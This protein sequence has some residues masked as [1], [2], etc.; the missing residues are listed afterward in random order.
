M[1]CYPQIKLADPHSVT[2]HWFNKLFDMFISPLMQLRPFQR[3]YSAAIKDPAA[4]DAWTKMLHL[5][6]T[7]LEISPNDLARIPKTG[8]LIVVANHPHGIMDGLFVGSLMHKVRDDFKIIMNEATTMPGLEDHLLFVSILG[9]AK[10]NARKNI[11]VM[12]KAIE[13]LK[14]GHAIVLFPAGEISSIKHFHE[15]IALDNTWNTNVIRLSTSGNAPILPILIVGQND[16]V[17]LKLGLIHPLLRTLQIGRVTNHLRNQTIKIRTAQLTQP[18]MLDVFKDPQTKTHFIRSQAYALL[19]KKTINARVFATPLSEVMS[20]D[21]QPSQLQAAFDCLIAQP[22]FKIREN[23]VYT[24]LLFNQ[25]QLHVLDATGTTFAVL[26]DEIGRLRE[27][28]FREVGEG[29]GRM[30]DL[31]RFDEYYSHLTLWD[32]ENKQLIGAY[33]IGFSDEILPQYG[34]QG[35]YT[36]QQFD[37]DPTFFDL[38]GPAMEISRAFI[39]KSH[40]KTNLGLST[41]FGAIAQILTERPQ[42]RSLF[43]AV[44]ISNEFQSASKKLIID[45]LKKHH[46]M[47]EL[48]PW[49]VA[50]NPPQLSV[51]IPETEWQNLVDLV[52]NLSLLN[53]VVTGIEEDGKNIPP[54]IPAYISLLARF[55][56]F[57]YDSDFNSIDGLLVVNLQALIKH[58][59]AI[60]LRLLGRKRFDEY[61]QRTT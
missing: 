53:A 15:K 4:L 55:V 12:R 9:S 28:T 23:S 21:I 52:H 48:N 11:Q 13:W 27:I 50:N 24:V 46:G 17:F 7:T 40:Q 58:N 32:S 16:P 61:V 33:R 36:A 29:S 42:V 51:Q 1:D 22:G 20:T 59:P 54:L 47:P 41:L 39:I 35:F 45:Y 6:N 19:S 57:D 43:G 26:K 10:E 49:V 56:A 37:F 34:K 3:A 25:Q 8:G 30:R 60:L 38:I 31:D 44:S 18:K 5:L 14:A 2:G